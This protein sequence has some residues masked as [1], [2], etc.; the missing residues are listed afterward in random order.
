MGLKPSTSGIGPSLY[1]TLRQP[2][3]AKRLATAGHSRR[4][5]RNGEFSRSRVELSAHGEK[6]IQCGVVRGLPLLLFVDEDGRVS[7]PVYEEVDDVAELVD[8][9]EENLGVAL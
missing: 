1:C 9:V 3:R 7:G 2:S 5:K 8:L 4:A 6:A